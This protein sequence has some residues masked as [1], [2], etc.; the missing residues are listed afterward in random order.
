MKSFSLEPHVV[1]AAHVQRRDGVWVADT[2][3]HRETVT[4]IHHAVQNVCADTDNLG[5][6]DGKIL[7]IAPYEKAV[8]AHLH[9]C[10]NGGGIPGG[11][12]ILRPELCICRELCR[13]LHETASRHEATAVV[14][15]RVPILLSRKKIEVAAEPLRKGK[16][17]GVLK[18]LIAEA[19]P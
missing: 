9:L 11:V 19:T 2:V 6:D 17:R 4:H 14:T 8:H 18:E 15:R 10:A 7:K 16:P 13:G 12:G 3:F 1:S 5:L